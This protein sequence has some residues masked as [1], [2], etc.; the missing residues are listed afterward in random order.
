[1][2]KRALLLVACIL[3][4]AG[5]AQSAEVG[6]E[7]EAT[8]TQSPAVAEVVSWWDGADSCDTPEIDT[9]ESLDGVV[10]EP[11]CRTDGQTAIAPLA[12]STQSSNPPLCEVPDLS[13]ERVR[14]PETAMIVGFP[15]KSH[16][17]DPIG[18]HKVSVVPVQF[19]DL[20]GSNSH[21]AEHRAQ[22]QEFSDYYRKISGG[23]LVFE[24]D[25]Y[26]AWLTM[27]G[28]QA[29]YSVNA[30][31]YRDS[32]GDRIVAMRE[33][34]MRDGV[35]L[36]DPVMDFTGTDIIIFVMPEN[37]RV[38]EATLQAF[39]GGDLQYMGQSD[40]G[41]IRNLFVIGM[42]GT[43]MRM[44]WAYY[45]HETGHTLS[46]PDWYSFN[47]GDSDEFLNTVGPMSTFEMMSSNWGPSLTMSAWTRWLAGWLEEDQ[48]VCFGADDFQPGSFELIDIDSE[49]EGLKS[50]MIRTSESTALI[51]ESRREQPFDEGPLSRSRNG[52]IVYEIDTTISHGQ[53]ALRL[54]LPEGRGMI[55]P[56]PQASGEASL[57]AVLYQGNS[58][59]H[60][61]FRV[62][63]NQV[64]ATDVVSIEKIN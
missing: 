52:V 64:G 57:D 22:V 33:K 40:E 47:F 51:V 23:K 14:Y 19:A 53:G 28:S 34:W 39:Y 25:M 5:C 20:P 15:R 10:R 50:V 62:L 55:F 59:E 58:V 43:P 61:G 21:L 31:E 17:V 42:P 2:R 60:S 41:E 54:I 38:L 63:V 45:A 1:M 26:D 24:I 29:D 13:D 18:T 48:F 56:Y 6:S 4:T 32:Y 11:N 9:F 12:R 44:Y 30:A 8:A 46:I 49:A 3:T 27:P 7:V 35:A 36:A 37:Q 16:N